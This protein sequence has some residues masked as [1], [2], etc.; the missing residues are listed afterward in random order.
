[1]RPKRLVIDASAVLKWYI[2]EDQYKEAL[3]VRS[4]FLTGQI[5]LLVPSFSLLEIFNRLER[6]PEVTVKDLYDLFSLLD[7]KPMTQED[8]VRTFELVRKQRRFEKHFTMYDA[9]YVQLAIM[10]KATLLTADEAQAKSARKLGCAV[11][12]LKDY[13]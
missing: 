6:E 7:A 5:D 9:L 12:A 10:E 8:L 11:I 1:M 2:I 3:K 13:E 4:D